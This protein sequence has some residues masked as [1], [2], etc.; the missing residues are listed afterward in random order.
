MY[1]TCSRGRRYYFGG[2]CYSL[3]SPASFCRQKKTEKKNE[4][5][6]DVYWPDFYCFK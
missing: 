1:N 6:P 4:F 5:Q 2:V 3:L